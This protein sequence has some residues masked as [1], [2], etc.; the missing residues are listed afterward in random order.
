MKLYK[1]KRQNKS[2]TFLIEKLAQFFFYRSLIKMT[3]AVY[4]NHRW[5]CC[6]NPPNH[7]YLP[8]S[9]M[10]PCYTRKLLYC[11]FLISQSFCLINNYCTSQLPSFNFSTLSTSGKH[12]SILFILTTFFSQ[13]A[14]QRRRE[15]FIRFYCQAES[16]SI[17]ELFLL[18]L[19]CGG[20]V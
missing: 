9:A 6:A 2:P 8:V 11:I 15:S 7:A 13:T 19:N 10:S 20:F 17:L 5:A 16:D 12:S 18:F 4:S 14:I 1:L 3:V